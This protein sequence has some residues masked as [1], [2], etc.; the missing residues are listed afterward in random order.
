MYQACIPVIFSQDAKNIEE[1]ETEVCVTVSDGTQYHGDVCIAADG[2]GS[3]LTKAITGVET[4]V[5][6]SGYAAARVA[7]PR[8][9]IKPGSPA[10]SLLTNVDKEPEFR[11]YLGNDLHGGQQWGCATYGRFGS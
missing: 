5:R 6:D 9:H 2:V 7:F 10:A 8:S 11:V 1:N 3:H 4:P